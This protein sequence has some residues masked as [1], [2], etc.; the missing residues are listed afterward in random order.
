[1]PRAANAV[2]T[3][4]A[5]F[6][7]DPFHFLAPVFD[8]LRE[9]EGYAWHPGEV[10]RQFVIFRPQQLG[11][12]DGAHAGRPFAT[13]EI[14]HLAYRFPRANCGNMNFIAGVIDPENLDPS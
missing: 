5:G 6:G 9:G 8:D 10:V 13:G 4:S 2:L 3:G 11:R 14:S 12:F 7:H 1:M